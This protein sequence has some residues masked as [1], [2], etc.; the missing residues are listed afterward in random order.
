MLRAN[1]QRGPVL[2]EAGRVVPLNQNTPPDHDIRAYLDTYVDV[3]PLREAADRGETEYT[4]F[5]E[6]YNEW[7]EGLHAICAE[8]FGGFCPWTP[9]PTK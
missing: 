6:A 2:I 5:D 9:Q 1:T 3:H 8:K 4:E 7:L